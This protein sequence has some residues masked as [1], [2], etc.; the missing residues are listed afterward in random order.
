MEVL[1]MATKGLKSW[2]KR[3]S[4]V[5]LPVL[6]GVV[7]ELNE[8]TGSDD[9]DV[10]QLSEVILR[11]ANL[12]SQVL[13]IANSA[14]YNPSSFPINTVSRA[15]VLIGF[16][17]VRAICISSMVIDSLLGNE[18]RER[19]LESMAKAFH[20]AVQSRSLIRRTNDEVKEEVFIAALLYHLGDMSFWACAGESADELDAALQKEGMSVRD[21]MTEV[22]GT[23]FK[24]ITR[25]LANI[26]KLGDTLREALDPP[27]TLPPRVVAV[28]MGEEISRNAIKG[29]DSQE[30][31]E[32]LY[33]VA[34]FTGL[35]FSQ[36]KS[37]VKEA[38]DEAASVALTYGA[39]RVCHLIP[40]SKQ[41]EQ[42]APEEDLRILKSDPQVQ[43]SILR[44]MSNAISENLD[45]NT[46]LQ[47]ALEG[48]HRGIGLE[49][50]I[51]SF[52]QKNTMFARYI[53]G[54]GT[55]D[56]RERFNFTIGPHDDNIFTYSIKER[57]PVWITAPFIERHKHLLSPDIVAL[58]G[59]TPCFI[60]VISIK[61]RDVAL[62][63]A[64]RSDFGGSLND[65]QFESFRHFVL[66]TQSSLE[67]IANKKN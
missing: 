66:Q 15:V 32:T 26:W 35:D 27:K 36:A 10:N 40:G 23:S 16:T 51:V 9:V 37:M 34:R 38:A 5:E 42:A 11:D 14:H 31:G 54:E 4:Q 3:L 1:G 18:P 56:W 64:D 48:L 2:V 29:W 57:E 28:L 44:E 47:M 67:L 61:G 49:R 52:I 43:L 50:V 25:E 58:L 41:I 6:A 13:R 62:F 46:V 17:G 12:T 20:A 55:E 33:K 24:A 65:Q 45:V 21:A 8:L 22:L 60:S 39:S 19:L 53:L 59:K 30:M 63:Y 7:K